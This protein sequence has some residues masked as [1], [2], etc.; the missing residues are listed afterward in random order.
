MTLGE[1]ITDSL[2]ILNEDT[3]TQ[4][5]AIVALV[6]IGINYWQR[7]LTNTMYVL[8][9]DSESTA[10]ADEMALPTDC[11]RLLYIIDAL[12]GDILSEN[13]YTVA[14][15]KVYF[16]NTQSSLTNVKFRY[17]YNPAKLVSSSGTPQIPADF[18]DLLAFGGASFY[19]LTQK[20]Y[21]LYEAYKQM[22][23]DVINNQM[24][25]NAN[26]MINPAIPETTTAG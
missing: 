11:V 7:M 23:T 3:E 16:K 10:W 6:T 9:K 15:A 14:G 12:S 26:A 5:A 13:D 21:N 24:P 22:I 1:I 4:D 17:T 8:A 2:K 18:H 19:C 25:L 20:K